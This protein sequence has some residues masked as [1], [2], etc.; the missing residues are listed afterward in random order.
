[1]M[2]R[3]RTVSKR[4]QAEIE[5]RERLRNERRALVAS[6]I[7][8]TAYALGHGEEKVTMG[9]S[10]CTKRELVCE[11]DVSA[12]TIR[13]PDGAWVCADVD[14]FMG[15]HLIPHNGSRAEQAEERLRKV[16]HAIMADSTDDL[17]LDGCQW[18]WCTI[19]LMDGDVSLG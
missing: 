14:M 19:A 7:R 1:M 10:S 6:A 9:G 15:C 5:E 18:L 16:V 2:G 12:T 11:G 3:S 13:F 4:E 8:E 17:S